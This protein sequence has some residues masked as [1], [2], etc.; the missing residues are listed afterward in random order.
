[1]IP[2]LKLKALGEAVWNH[3][4][5][6]RRERRKERLRQTEKLEMLEYEQPFLGIAIEQPFFAHLEPM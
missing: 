3:G 4:Q 5:W 2:R 6:G 1:M